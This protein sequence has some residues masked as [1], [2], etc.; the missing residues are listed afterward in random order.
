MLPGVGG[1]YPLFPSI[2][3]LTNRK[4]GCSFWLNLP[5]GAFTVA[6]IIFCFS[7]PKDQKVS[8]D[9]LLTKIR[10]LNLAN[11]A[12]FIGSA[13][14]LLLA[15]Q[16]GGTTYPWSNGRIIALL[17]ISAVSFIGF[18]T[19]EVLMKER[20]TI[21]LRVIADR[22]VALSLVYGFCTAAAL[23]I[24]DYFVS[25]FLSE[26][27]WA[28]RTHGFVPARCLSGFKLSRVLRPSNPVSGSFRL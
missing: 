5:I 6:V 1:K 25:T 8:D 11:L 3:S 9:P 18:V 4:P 15:L 20:A 7:N 22:T 28:C 13:V 21:S 2:M 19:M 10:Q 24:M 12:V 27:M 14:C 26:P 16:W 17:V 23:S